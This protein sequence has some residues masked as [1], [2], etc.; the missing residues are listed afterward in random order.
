MTLRYLIKR[1][2]LTIPTLFGIMSHHLRD[3]SIRSGW[4]R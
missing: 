4:S 1:L 2:L 3:Y